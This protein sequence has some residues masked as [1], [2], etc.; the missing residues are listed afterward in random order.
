MLFR[1]A[2]PFSLYKTLEDWAKENG[3]AAIF[4][5]ALDDDRVEKTSKFYA[6]AGYKPLER[7]FA[8]GAGSWL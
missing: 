8:K 3:A 2:A 5:I 4:M 7:T 6:R 1:S